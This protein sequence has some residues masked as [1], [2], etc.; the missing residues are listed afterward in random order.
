MSWS[1]FVPPVTVLLGGIGPQS[2]IMMF[3][4]I[5]MYFVVVL[6]MGDTS[7][8]YSVFSVSPVMLDVFSAKTGE[9]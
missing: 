7:F 1:P 8:L 3:I 9:M 6:V 4:S 2:A 5:V